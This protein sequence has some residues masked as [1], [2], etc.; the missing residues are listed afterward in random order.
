MC[1]GITVIYHYLPSISTGVPSLYSVVLLDL[2]AVWCLTVT[3]I[4]SNS[5]SK[6]EF[7]RDPTKGVPDSIDS[8]LLL[9]RT[10]RRLRIEGLLFI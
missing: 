9:L 5:L 7:R 2:P 3:Y 10:V 8:V 6:S 1:I 4:H